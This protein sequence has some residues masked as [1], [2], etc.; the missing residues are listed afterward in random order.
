MP[1]ISYR[2][3]PVLPGLFRSGGRSL[4]RE[5]V[6]PLTNSALRLGQGTKGLSIGSRD[7]SSIRTRAVRRPKPLV[8]L[9]GGRE[10]EQSFE[11][12]ET[13]DSVL[14]SKASEALRRFLP[15][16]FPNKFQEGEQPEVEWVIVV[17]YHDGI[18]RVNRFL[19][20]NY[21][22]YIAERPLCE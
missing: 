9:G 11:L 12:N 8:I 7:H 5:P 21:G 1:R 13:D 17:S 19:D 14:G 10:A 2:F 16:V 22:F 4:P 15:A 3:S 20:W 18:K 6:S